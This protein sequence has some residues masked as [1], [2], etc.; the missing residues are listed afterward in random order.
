M[1]AGNV[2]PIKALSDSVEWRSRENEEETGLALEIFSAGSSREG[3]DVEVVS[4]AFVSRNE[5]SAR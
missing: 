4:I 1:C 2:L 5:V 3:S